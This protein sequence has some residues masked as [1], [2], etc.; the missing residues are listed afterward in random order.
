MKSPAIP[1]N[2]KARIAALCN[3]EILDTES[4][5]RFDLFTRI[6]KSHFD[7][8]IV[9]VSLVD[10]ARQ[11]F[12]SRQ[13]LDATET[14]RDISFCGHAILSHDI[15]YIPDTL[16]DPRFFDNPLVTNAPNIR[17][18]AGAPL[19]TPDKQRIGTL[20]IIDSKPREFTKAQLATL[21][22]LADGVEAE[23]SRA[24]MI[25][26]QEI[27]TQSE[28]N[29][30]IKS[31]RLALA[32]KAGNIG[33][34]DYDVVGGVLNWDERMFSLYGVERNQFPGC[35]EA[36]SH[37]LHPED[38]VQAEKDLSDALSGIKPFDCEFRVIWSDN[39]VRFIKANA[40]VIRDK[41]G[42][43]LRMTGINQDIT[44]RK[45]IERLKSEF[46]S[47]ISHELRTPLTSI[48]GALGLIIGK[49]AENLPEQFQKMLALANRNAE[50][51]TLLINDILDLERI[52]SDLLIF[53]FKEIDIVAVATRS[54]EDNAGYSAKHNV[55]LAFH[56]KIKNGIVWGD[57]NRLLQV[58]ANLISNAI[59]FSPKGETVVINIEHIDSTFRVSVSDAGNGIPDD[60]RHR[61]FQRFAQADSSDSRAKGGTGL[62]LNITHAI[63]KRHG[64]TIDYTSELGRGTQFYFEL[65]ELKAVQLQNIENSSAPLVL[66]CEDNVDIAEILAA[67]IKPAGVHCDFAITAAQTREL[68]SQRPYSL[69][70]LDLNLPDSKGIDFLLELRSNEATKK[71][72]VIVVSGQALEGKN[73]LPDDDM[74]VVDWLQKPIGQNRLQLALQAALKKSPHPHVLH[75]EDDTDI[76]QIT[77]ALIEDHVEYSFATSQAE[78]RQLLAHQQFDLII[79]DLSLPDG[80]GFDLLVEINNQCPV[81]IFSA[82][83]V[84]ENIAAQVDFALTKSVT[85]NSQL[86][87]T[88]IALLANKP[89]G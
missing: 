30:R 86:Q 9:L 41:Q 57:E 16:A 56:S 14:P 3:L 29:L 8:P 62:G 28:S 71:L 76:I 49:A 83:D 20:C 6:A 22:D 46:I 69:L 68:L 78:A 4:E 13:G 64:G 31:E 23:L 12:K 10:E 36:W 51:L 73:I 72:P 89:S 15:F 40:T 58:F 1:S 45:E 2:E 81:I 37:A 87:K 88:I 25:K 84:D 52:E 70:V 54:L 63:I 77:R 67:M 38:K 11:W 34:W 39:K 26:M 82:N 35:Y 19:S 48:R 47:T 60:F 27:V 24:N 55:K 33:V 74:M 61:I 43:A 65:P 21:R 5:E 59:K 44:E 79:L 66:I 53:E 18:Y 75:I 80:C 50:R 85:S 32:T 7:V 42:N 17:F